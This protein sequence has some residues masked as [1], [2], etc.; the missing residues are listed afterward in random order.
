MPIFGNDTH[1]SIVAGVQQGILAEI[2]LTISEYRLQK[3]D[4]IS[5][6]TGGDCFFL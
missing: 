3:P 6:V 1:S 2:K 5:V 4:T